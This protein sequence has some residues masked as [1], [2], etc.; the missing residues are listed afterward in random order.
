MAV[1]GTF[2]S[3]Y[4]YYLIHRL[5]RNGF[6]FYLG[7]FSAA[8]FSVLT[9]SIVCSFE[10]AMSGT[11]ELSKVLPAMASVHARIGIAEALIT[12]MAVEVLKSIRF[13]LDGEI[14]NEE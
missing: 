7:I 11:I 8:F 1:I 14:K 3:Y 5:F 10:V 2:G 6:G 12:I 9:A 4:I 13:D